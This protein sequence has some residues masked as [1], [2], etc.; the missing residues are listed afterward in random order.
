MKALVSTPIDYMD[1][2]SGPK[3]PP[4]APETQI[5]IQK[6][7]EKKMYLPKRKSVKTKW[8]METYSNSFQRLN[9][10]F[11]ESLF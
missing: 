4:Y 1:V 5:I 6:E 9:A 10:V 3:I 7:L 2:P 11:A 8:P